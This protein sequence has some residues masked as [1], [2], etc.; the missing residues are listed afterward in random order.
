[1]AKDPTEAAAIIELPSELERWQREDPAEVAKTQA[2]LRE[3]F[4][5]WFDKGYA[6][7]A[8]RTGPT[9]RAYLLTP[10]SDF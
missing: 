9:N 8:L 1:L 3:E 4:T 5:E 2:R 7:V 6:A 10:W